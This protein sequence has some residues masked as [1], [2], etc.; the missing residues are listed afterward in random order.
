MS[1]I[2]RR[3]RSSSSTDEG[4]RS[5]LL[6]VVVALLAIV[7]RRRLVLGLVHDDVVWKGD[8]RAHLALGVVRQHDLH[9]DAKHSLAHGNMAH[10]LVDIVLLRLARGDQVTI[11]ELHR[12]RALRAKLSAD[13][14]LAALGTVLH[15]EADHAVA[16]AAHSEASE[17]LVAER[18][19][20]SHRATRTIL[21][22]LCEEL[23]A[24]LGKTVTLLHHGR[25]LPDAAA[26][27]AED[28]ARARRADDDLGTNGCD[29][30]LH[31]RIAVLGKSPHQELVQL[32]VEDAIGH[33]LALLR[34]LRLG[35][36]LAAVRLSG[37][38]L[39]A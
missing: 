2:V 10:G 38:A 14:H 37:Q 23:N 31:T 35:R 15:D 8:L 25:E 18:L 32:R 5:T 7:H 28:L 16:R 29:T 12:L 34:D 1:S 6:V 27:L 4:R 33:E 22:T 39:T 26:L 20:L 19:G 36:H 24:V 9:L 17:Q 3:P 11:P 21:D 13:H 30:H